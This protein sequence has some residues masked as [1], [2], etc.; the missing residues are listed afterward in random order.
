[1][2]KSR[3]T[4]KQSL[5][6]L[7]TALLQSAGRLWHYVREKKRLE[8]TFYFSQDWIPWRQKATVIGR[9]GETE[10]GFP[11]DRKQR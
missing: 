4:A 11:G 9:N 8:N 3:Q 1:M 6:V 2:I 7:A 5:A 10:T